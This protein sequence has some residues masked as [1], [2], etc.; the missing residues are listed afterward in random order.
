MTTFS[1][2]D[3]K[4][5]RVDRELR[6][7]TRRHGQV[8]ELCAFRWHVQHPSGQHTVR[9]TRRDPDTQVAATDSQL[10][11][12]LNLAFTDLGAAA[13]A[14]AH[15]GAL[16][17]RRLAPRVRQIHEL[18][19]QLDTLAIATPTGVADRSAPAQRAATA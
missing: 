6:D 15:H 13:F 7:L 2:A 11:H 3:S 14:L 5:K 16:N 9:P 10:R 12:D 19:A 4:L 18:V 17:D 8:L 1:T